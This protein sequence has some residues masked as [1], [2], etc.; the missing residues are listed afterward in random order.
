MKVTIEKLDAARSQLRTSIKLFFEDRDPV[1]THTLACAALAI[2]HD[3]IPSEEAWKHDIMLHY[4]TIFIKDEGRKIWAGKIREAANF[5]KHADNDLKIGKTHIEFTP[6][7]TK[8]YIM[9]AIQCIRILDGK[10]AEAKDMVYMTFITWLLQNHPDLLK[11]EGKQMMPA[12]FYDYPTDKKTALAAI[13]FLD[14]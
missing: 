8:F 9:E 2:L 14:R 4:N 5:F 1:S 12:G 13:E 7:L 10:G 3:H 6:D 11:E